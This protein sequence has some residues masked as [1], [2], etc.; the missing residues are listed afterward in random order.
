M[1]RLPL[2]AA[3]PYALYFSDPFAWPLVVWAGFAEDPDNAL[4]Q[5]ATATGSEIGHGREDEGSPA[6]LCWCNAACIELADPADVEA[7]EFPDSEIAE[8]ARQR[9]EVVTPT[10]YCLPKNL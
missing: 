1:G 8:A 10:T 9:G 4:R 6:R 3:K 7:F 2:N 5:F